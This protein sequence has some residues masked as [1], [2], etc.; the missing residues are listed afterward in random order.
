MLIRG[1][2]GPPMKIGRKQIG[3]SGFQGG[4]RKEK[5]P[6]VLGFWTGSRQ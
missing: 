1:I 5:G 4:M 2:I 3:G 6:S